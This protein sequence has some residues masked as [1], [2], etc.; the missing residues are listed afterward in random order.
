MSGNKMAP[1]RR[2]EENSKES[3]SASKDMVSRE[4]PA[5][6]H[7]TISARTTIAAGIKLTFSAAITDLKAD[8]LVLTEQLTAAQ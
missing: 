4:S 3:A 1:A 5:D 6:M 7:L 8:I 2:D